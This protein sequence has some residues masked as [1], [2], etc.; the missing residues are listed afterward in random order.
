MKQLSLKIET[1][2]GRFKVRQ[3]DAQGIRP[4]LVGS[5]IN[6]TEYGG[7]DRMKEVLK[8][9]VGGYAIS[10]GCIGD[11]SSVWTEPNTLL[12]V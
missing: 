5:N 10:R 2:L 12:F 6:A 9:G 7:I 1:Q 4:K 8:N 11:A 3:D